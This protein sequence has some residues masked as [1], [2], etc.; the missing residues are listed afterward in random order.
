MKFA[1]AHSTTKQP[2]VYCP[3][4]T[5][6]LYGWYMLIYVQGKNGDLYKDYTN[7]R[8]RAD[9]SAPVTHVR[10]GTQPLEVENLSRIVFAIYYILGYTL[11]KQT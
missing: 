3:S 4:N 1:T 5:F 11:G 9:N 2:S 7:L 8:M 6:E 10:V